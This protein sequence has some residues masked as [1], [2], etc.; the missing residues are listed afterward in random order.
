M[1]IGLL[2]IKLLLIYDSVFL[3]NTKLISGSVVHMYYRRTIG[4]K[5]VKRAKK[6][7]IPVRMF[8]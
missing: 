4:L 2:R 1:L 8:P 6:K 3:F 5:A 7:E